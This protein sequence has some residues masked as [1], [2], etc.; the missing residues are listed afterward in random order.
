MHVC[1]RLRI[2]IIGTVCE[3][4][5]ERKGE[6][7]RQSASVR[8]VDQ[9]REGKGRKP[10]NSS[11]INIFIILQFRLFVNY[12]FIILRF[13]SPKS[14]MSVQTYIIVHLPNLPV[15][16]SYRKSRLGQKSEGPARMNVSVDIDS[17]PGLLRANSLQCVS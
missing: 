3:T 16:K 11:S 10:S 5:M 9:E 6:K 13:L 7:P 12:K 2:K 14:S 17:K 8:K 1:I 4:K 15:A